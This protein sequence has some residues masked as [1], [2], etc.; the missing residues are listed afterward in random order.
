MAFLEGASCPSVATAWG[1]GPGRGSTAGRLVACQEWIADQVAVSALETQ[2]LTFVVKL[3][4][5]TR[6]SDPKFEG[7]CSEELV[8]LLG[9]P[10]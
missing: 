10:G 5:F 9:H 8:H 4:N 7:L 3:R 6:A 2:H 1:I